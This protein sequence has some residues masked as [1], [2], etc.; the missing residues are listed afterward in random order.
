MMRA[1]VRC[2][3]VTDFGGNA[4]EVKFSPVAAKL[5]PADGTD[6]DN[7]YAKWS[8]SGEFKLTITNPALH[9]KIK[10]GMVF[11]VDFAEVIEIPVQA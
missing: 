1:K 7:T 3:Q 2:N 11:Y 8:P 5:Y 6:E 10:P 9:G 4:Q